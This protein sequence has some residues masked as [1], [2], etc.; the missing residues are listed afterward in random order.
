MP[1]FLAF[2]FYYYVDVGE[3]R[4]LTSGEIE[5]LSEIYGSNVEYSNIKIYPRKF[6]FSLFL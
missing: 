5:F 1:L 2:Q 6:F 4:N 3:H